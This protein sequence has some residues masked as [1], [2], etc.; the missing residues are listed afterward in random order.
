M[1][2][3]KNFIPLAETSLGQLKSISDKKR[4][5]KY[6]PSLMKL[7]RVKN[8]LKNVENPSFKRFEYNLYCFMCTKKQHKTKLQKYDD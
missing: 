1:S 8:K 5:R 7:L 2:R 6:R 3:N 4:I